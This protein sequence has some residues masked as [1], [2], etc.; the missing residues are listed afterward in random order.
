MCCISAQALPLASCRKATILAAHGF[1]PTI[2]LVPTM[3]NASSDRSKHDPF[4]TL[5]PGM[6][7]TVVAFRSAK[8]GWQWRTKLIWKHRPTLGVK[9][10][11]LGKCKKQN[12]KNL[13]LW[14][15]DVETTKYIHDDLGLS[16]AEFLHHS[17]A[18]H[19]CASS[20]HEV[21]RN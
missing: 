14:K 5:S 3:T 11:R 21:P 6:Y 20:Q 18:K 2:C 7:S 16:P 10:S 13:A 8:T 12:G 1:V 15:S 17:V 4:S 9:S 19:S